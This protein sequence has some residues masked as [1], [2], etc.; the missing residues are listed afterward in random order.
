MSESVPAAINPG[1][2]TKKVRSGG[3]DSGARGFAP[4]VN[5]KSSNETKSRANLEFPD[6][7]FAQPIFAQRATLLLQTL[8]ALV[9][10]GNLA[11]VAGWEQIGSTLEENSTCG[12]FERLKSTGLAGRNPDPHKSLS[13]LEP[14][15]A[16]WL[17][18]CTH[19]PSMNTC[20]ANGADT[21]LRSTANTA[22][23]RTALI[24][25][26]VVLVAFERLR[27]RIMKS[28]N[29]PLPASNCTV[30]VSPPGFA[31]VNRG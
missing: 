15:A 25:P 8:F 28:K 12:S 16:H 22:N 30:S 27:C 6:C 21:A 19:I 2:S 23:G 20:W 9:P 5:L 4:G 17:A 10:V 11:T 31:F 26:C 18:L 13:L 29:F 3:V 24:S 14:V 1:L 7:V